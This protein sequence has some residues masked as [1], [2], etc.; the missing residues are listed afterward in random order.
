MMAW[1]NGILTWMVDALSKRWTA[2]VITWLGGGVAIGFFSQTAL[3]AL[4]SAAS[5]SLSSIPAT[6]AQLAALSGLDVAL[7]II[8]GAY[9]AAIGIKATTGSME[10]NR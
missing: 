8:A 9:T 6:V 3:D 7:A 10:I 1:L 5:S 2:S 4:F